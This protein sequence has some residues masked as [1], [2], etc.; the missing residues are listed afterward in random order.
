MIWDRQQATVHLTDSHASNFVSNVLT[1]LVEKRLAL[2]VS[3]P[4]AFTKITFNGAA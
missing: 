3:R 1:L 2:E 4:A